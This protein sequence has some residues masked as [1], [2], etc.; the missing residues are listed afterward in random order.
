MARSIRLL[1]ADPD[2][3][4][5]PP[6]RARHRA[7]HVT[8]GVMMTPAERDALAARARAAGLSMG[9]LLRGDRDAREAE[10]EVLRQRA[11]RQGL[12]EGR[13]ERGSEVEGLRRDLAAA[14]AAGE[15]R[16]R[17][18]AAAWRAA[19]QVECDAMGEL[20]AV[21]VARAPLASY[22]TDPGR[23]S[24]LDDF[25]ARLKDRLGGIPPPLGGWPKG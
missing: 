20:R 7:E 24:Y 23:R 12:D 6:S 15:A 21:V 9:S 19:F 4:R 25:D 5:E 14:T 11:R 2:P 8:V 17:A 13:G 18:V 1:K 16:V 3:H 10:L 22:Q